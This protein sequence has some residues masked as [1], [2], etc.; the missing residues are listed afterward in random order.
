VIAI[1]DKVTGGYMKHDEMQG[2][3]QQHGVSVV[4]RVGVEL[5]GGKVCD[6]EKWMS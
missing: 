1:R 4:M 2:V 3:C 5:T 6:V